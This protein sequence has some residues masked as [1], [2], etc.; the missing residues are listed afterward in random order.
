[1]SISERERQALDSIESELAGS[2]PR[3]AA[4]LGMF[5]RLTAGERMPRREPIRSITAKAA[6]AGI[7][8]G[9]AGRWRVRGR[10]IGRNTRGWLWVA[11][12]A[13]L[14]TVMVTL[15]HGTQVSACAHSL[16]IACQRTPT[17]FQPGA[18]E[19]GR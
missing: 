7:A 12:L 11:V 16:T 10:H 9:R 5:A 19:R 8:G 2:A 17:G 18:Q 13:A 6:G 14:L 4:M 15:T 3:L 1:M